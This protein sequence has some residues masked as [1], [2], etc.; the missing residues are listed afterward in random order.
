MTGLILNYIL[1]L[2]VAWVNFWCGDGFTEFE[3]IPLKYYLM[4]LLID[5]PLIYLL[6]VK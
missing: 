5:I 4:G 2:V 6:F 3:R 1:H